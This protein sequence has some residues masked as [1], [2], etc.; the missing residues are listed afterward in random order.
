MDLEDI[1][2]CQC[3][4]LPKKEKKMIDDKVHDLAISTVRGQ[5]KV[6]K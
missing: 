5:S 3:V 4:G 1:L 6:S 2:T